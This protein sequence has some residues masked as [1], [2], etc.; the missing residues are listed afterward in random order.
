M[1]PDWLKVLAC[2]IT[3]LALKYD[4]HHQVL[5]SEQIGKAYPIRDGI[6]VLLAEEAIDWPIQIEQEA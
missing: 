3:K 5:I 1:N 4:A 2:P 6:P